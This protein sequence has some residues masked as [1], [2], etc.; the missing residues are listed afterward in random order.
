MDKNFSRCGE[1][2]I[3]VFHSMSRDI[4]IGKVA[5]YGL[6]SCGPLVPWDRG[7]VWPWERGSVGAWERGSVGAW[8]R[9]SVGAWERGSVG[10][11]D[12]GSLYL[13]LGRHIE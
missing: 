11:W 7:A 6:G 10:A 4:L 2:H 1:I 13:F 12:R 3:K 5:A 9:G 8:E